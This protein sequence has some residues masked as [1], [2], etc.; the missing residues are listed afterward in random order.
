MHIIVNYTCLQLAKYKEEHVDKTQLNNEVPLLSLPPELLHHIL[1]Y[2]TEPK[3]QQNVLLTSKKFSVLGLDDRAFGE[4]IFT[5]KYLM[6]AIYV[7]SLETV[8]FLLSDK[9][10]DP[11]A[12]N[13]EAI[14]EASSKGHVEIV[15]E[16]LKDTR[17]DPSDQNNGALVGACTHGHEEVVKELLKI[18]A[19]K[20][21]FFIKKEDLGTNYIRCSYAPE[22]IKAASD[23]R[24]EEALLALL[25]PEKWEK[26]MHIRTND[27]VIFDTYF[28]KRMRVV[29]W[30]RN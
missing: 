29:V 9:R 15:N 13:N 18:E 4:Q 27:F 11:S 5:H 14:I 16:L 10:V 23:N 22:P 20:K 19:V 24:H 1:S 2:I 17:I 7:N 3:N 8:K 12:E 21:L 30:L 28:I 6:N 26:T 25:T